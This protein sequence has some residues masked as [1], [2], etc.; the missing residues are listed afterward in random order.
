MIG[1]HTSNISAKSAQSRYLESRVREDQRC[2]CSMRNQLSSEPTHRMD[3]RN[4]Y[5]QFNTSHLTAYV[6]HSF[7][8]IHE[9]TFR[10]GRHRR[11]LSTSRTPTNERFRCASRTPPYNP[12]HV[13]RGRNDN[14]R[15]GDCKPD[16]RRQGG[17]SWMKTGSMHLP[18]IDRFQVG[19]SNDIRYYIYEV[20][21]GHGN[22][23]ERDEGR[24][25]G[26]Q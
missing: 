6:I 18:A 25:N 17:T 8:L 15:A 26:W 19:Q 9:S 21:S 5:L 23:K 10:G 13:S 22:R 12:C 20:L 2:A 14:S 11:P 1:D 3:G 16:S 4:T 24:W 7:F